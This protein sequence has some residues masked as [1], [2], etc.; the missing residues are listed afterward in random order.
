M[1]FREREF[2]GRI[3]RRIGQRVRVDALRFVRARVAVKA[4]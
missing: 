3:V 4:R 2:R 1:V